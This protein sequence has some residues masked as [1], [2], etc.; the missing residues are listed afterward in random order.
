MI[1]KLTTY[2]LLCATFF[3]TACESGKGVTASE[4]GDQWPL[5]VDSGRIDCIAP[6]AA[7]FIYD[8]TTYQ[9]N[10]M[11]Q[12]QGYARINPIWR[13]NPEIPGAKISISPLLKAALELC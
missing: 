3:L 12:S 6:G 7:I 1:M 8:G 2:G 11:A 13:N 5:S 10:G 4:F 9:L